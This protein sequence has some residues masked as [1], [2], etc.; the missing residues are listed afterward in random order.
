[1]ARQ[2]EKE[3]AQAKEAL[4]MEQIMEAQRKVNEAKALK[5]AQTAAEVP[6]KAAAKAAEPLSKDTSLMSESSDT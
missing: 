5:L 4:M 2:K 3:L 6:K 1:M